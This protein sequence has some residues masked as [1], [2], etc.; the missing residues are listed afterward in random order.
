MPI[1][2]VIP[3]Y[4]DN[5]QPLW[6]YTVCFI[7]LANTVLYKH[8]LTSYSREVP[9]LN[10][11]LDRSCGLDC[12]SSV[13]VG[14]TKQTTHGTGELSLGNK[15]WGYT[16]ANSRLNHCRKINRFYLVK[17]YLVMAGT[18]TH[19]LCGRD[20]QLLCCDF[21]CCVGQKSFPFFCPEKVN[22]DALILRR[23]TQARICPWSW[24][25]W[26]PTSRHG[27]NRIS[28]GH[29]HTYT[30]VNQCIWLL[31]YSAVALDKITQRYALRSA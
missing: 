29:T 13:T 28:D 18:L 27:D 8:R 5:R 15:H 4:K 14:C 21:S 3:K 7:C 17:V 6:I 24:T 11:P 25:R 23:L 2:K 1:P 9:G 26:P 12:T 16:R 19:S 22:M 10:C 30:N 20:A 31:G